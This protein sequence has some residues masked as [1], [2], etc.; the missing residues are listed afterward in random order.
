MKILILIALLV[1]VWTPVKGS[2]YVYNYNLENNIVS[3]QTVYCKN[4]DGKYIYPKLKYNF[5]YDDQ[6]RIVR[7][8][9]QQWDVQSKSWKK[10]HCLNWIFTTDGFVIEYI[11]WNKNANDYTEMQEKQVVIKLNDNFL[12]MSIF[13]WD[14]G[15]SNWTLKNNA[16][17]LNSSNIY[18]YY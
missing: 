2:D 13:K 1:Y 6:Q 9:V 3:S 17:V 15:N 12:S 18:T 5:T 16:L 7:K 11:N 10:S 14:Q 4:H 8:E